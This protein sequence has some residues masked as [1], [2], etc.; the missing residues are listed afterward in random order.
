VYSTAVGYVGG[1]LP[2]PSYEQVCSG[3]TGHTEGTIVYYEPEKISFA[4][5]MVQFWMCHNPTQVNG[6]GHDHGTQYRSAIFI[7]DDEQ[8]AL[9]N[10]SKTAFET[11]LGKHG[12]PKI[13]TEIGK[14]KTFYYAENYHQQYLA[15][16][17]SRQY[18]SAQPTGIQ[19]PMIEDWVLP[20]ELK[21]KYAHKLPLQFWQ[22]HGPK[23][24]CTINCPDGQ[25]EWKLTSTL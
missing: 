20:Q 19:S 25:I 24:G 9:V 5:L 14:D 11:E 22:Q 18:C 13:A 15:K 23:P 1:S 8:L 16:P 10:A 3:Q 6:Q 12:Y 2:H 7:T 21:D 17:G 4:D